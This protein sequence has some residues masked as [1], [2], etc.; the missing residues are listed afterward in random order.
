MQTKRY[1]VRKTERLKVQFN[2][3]ANPP[4]GELFFQPHKA[5]KTSVLN[6]NYKLTDTLLLW[7]T[8]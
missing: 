2:T 6:V 7:Q 4:S 3:K 8:Q 5:K 1:G